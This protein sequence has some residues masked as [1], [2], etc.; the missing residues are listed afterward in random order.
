VP[1]SRSPA[2]GYRERWIAPWWWWLSALGLGVLV[3]AEVHGGAA[4]LRAWLPYAVAPPL[5]LAL[6]ALGSRGRVTVQ[7]EVLHVPGA[8]IELAAL[9]G[10]VVLDREA[11][12]QQTGPMADRRAF[13]VSRPW[14]HTGV[15]VMVTDDADPTPY[16][17]IGSRHPDR[18]AA[19][20]R[21]E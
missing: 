4:G 14:L 16:W 10:P 7:D 11:L 18:L 13:V 1:V 20:L 15:R 8:R 9:A 3:A 19:A 21:Q 17:V 5:A 2:G 6:L 12:R